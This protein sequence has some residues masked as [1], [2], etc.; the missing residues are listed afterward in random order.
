MTR[1]CCTAETDGGLRG[2]GIS[3][4]YRIIL[5]KPKECVMLE[6]MIREIRQSGRKVESSGKIAGVV[7]E[8]KGGYRNAGKN[9]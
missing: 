4:I 3:A 9:V 5:K 7:R 2:G 6:N 1:G 8:N